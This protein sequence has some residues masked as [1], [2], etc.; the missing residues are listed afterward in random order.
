M[1]INKNNNRSNQ[2]PNRKRK[3]D[4]FQW[5]KA[6]K[7][8]L[9]WIAILVAAI[10]FSTLWPSSEEGAAKISY[11]EYQTILKDNNMEKGEVIVKEN[12]LI[13]ETRQPVIVGDKGQTITRFK[14]V[15]PYLDDTMV[16]TPSS[17]WTIILINSLPWILI[18]VVWIFIARRMQGGGG[19]KGIFSFGKSRAKMFTEEKMKVTFADVAGADEAKQELQ[20]IIEFLQDPAKFQRLGG[21]IPKGALLLGPPGTGKTLLAKAVAGEAGVPFFSMSG[22]DFVEMFVGVGASRVRDLFETGRKHAP[23]IL[24][25]DEMDAVGRHRGAGLGGG[26]D[27]REQT[28]NQLLVE[29]DGFDTK[30]GVILLAATNRPDVLD[31]ALLRPGRFDRQIVVDRPDV[32]GREGI[33]KVHT[34]KTPL[35]SDIDLEVLAKGTPGLSG[36][37]LANLVNEAAL[38]AARRNR[39][40][41]VMADFEEAKDKVMMGMERKSMIINEEEKKS[42]AFHESGHV[43]VSRLLPETDPVHKVTIIPRGTAL[44][45]TSYLPIDEKH[46]YSKSYLKSMLAQLLGGRAAEKIVLDQFTTGAG[47]DIEQATELARKM[48][49]EWGMSDILGPVTFGKKEEEIFLGREISQHR[50]YSE[51]TAKEI[52]KEVRRIITEAQ[53]IALNLL[54][55]NIK[56]LHDLANALLEYEILD[57]E[58]IEKVMKGQKLTPR[59]EKTTTTEKKTRAKKKTRPARV[60]KKSG[61]V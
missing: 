35:A 50:D 25:I 56:L 30:E 29:M 32:R 17:E 48:V 37:D 46:N 61:E 57:G 41:I 38:L 6:S 59:K 58:Q 15:L 8:G 51:E 39:D 12:I 42:T 45:V 7:T 27:E 22:A 9:I 53:E 40:K 31:S 4:E 47:N 13:G 44:G 5:K 55:K 16:V 20:E 2:D 11:S 24:F 10:F 34:K 36:A 14:T 21:K 33:L 1:Q 26:H 54:T 52:D 43:L 3:N 23:C 49:C 60:T 18:L 28:L 19:A